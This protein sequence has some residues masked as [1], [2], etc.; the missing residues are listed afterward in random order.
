MRKLGVIRW[1]FLGNVLIQVIGNK[2]CTLSKH[3]TSQGLSHAGGGRG[4]QNKYKEEIHLVIKLINNKI[5]HKRYRSVG[6]N[7]KFLTIFKN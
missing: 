1:M 7:C 4:L 5:D 2:L 6:T 3:R